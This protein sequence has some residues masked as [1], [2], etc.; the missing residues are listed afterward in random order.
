[1]PVTEL[2]KRNAAEHGKEVA[3]VEI[4]PTM[5]ET[6]KFSYKEYDL[7]QQTKPTK[8]YRRQLRKRASRVWLPSSEW[9]P[10]SRR[11]T[12]RD[13]VHF[14][15]MLRL[16]RSSRRVKSRYGSAETAVTS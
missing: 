11:D 12:R 14:S 4:N 9:L 7:V 5:E 6:R 2:L 1:M 3:L 13:T 8:Y 10:L 15:I 16:P